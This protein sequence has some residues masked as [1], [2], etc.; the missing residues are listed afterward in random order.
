MI[1][2]QHLEY[3]FV[4]HAGI[5][6]TSGLALSIKFDVTDD[7][8]Q[9]EDLIK[10]FCDVIDGVADYDD[11]ADM[12]WLCRCCCEGFNGFILLEMTINGC[13]QT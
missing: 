5:Y 13:L 4:L 8:K 12:S 2:D 6:L 3:L 9:I 11:T 1:L 7:G 10:S